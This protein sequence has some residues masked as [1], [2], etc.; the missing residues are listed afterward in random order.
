EGLPVAQFADRNESVEKMLRQLPGIVYE[1]GKPEENREAEARRQ[2]ALRREPHDGLR[3]A[4]EEE[5]E[6]SLSARL[7]VVFKTVE[8]LGQI[9]KT[10]YSRIPRVRREAVIREMLDGPL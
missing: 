10:Q 2:D 1:G 8:I 7:T 3:D 9:L 4:A 6:L 5:E